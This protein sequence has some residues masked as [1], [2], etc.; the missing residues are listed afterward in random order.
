LGFGEVLGGGVRDGNGVEELGRERL[1]GFGREEVLWRIGEKQWTGEGG[2]GNAGAQRGHLMA[3]LPQPVVAA[4]SRSYT[5]ARSVPEGA[6]VCNVEHRM[7]DREAFARAPG[8]YA[9]VVSHNVDSGNT[10]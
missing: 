2:G 8:D 5:P 10:R 1:L 6:V 4:S 7:G 9:I 3:D